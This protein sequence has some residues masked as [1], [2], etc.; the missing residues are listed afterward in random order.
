MEI[1]DKSNM[2]CPYCKNNVSIYLSMSEAKPNNEQTRENFEK[3]ESDC[4]K[5]FKKTSILYKY[6]VFLKD[7]R[8]RNEDTFI[9]LLIQFLNN[10]ATFDWVKNLKVKNVLLFI[11]DDESK[12]CRL[13]RSYISEHIL[14]KDDFLLPEGITKNKFFY[15]I[16]ACITEN[17]KHLSTL[18]D[19]LHDIRHEMNRFTPDQLLEM[20]D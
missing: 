4:A 5:A 17:K 1:Y 7:L 9:L 16:K 8:I 13:L 10:G 11:G 15:S 12:I 20:I 14:L 19:K 2:T 3:A 18:P 6:Q